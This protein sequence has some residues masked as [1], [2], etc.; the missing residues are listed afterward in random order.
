MSRRVAQAFAIG[1]RR[2]I[3]APGAVMVDGGSELGLGVSELV[4]FHDASQAFGNGRSGCLTL[5]TLRVRSARP[6]GPRTIAELSA[7]R[8]QAAA[9]ACATQADR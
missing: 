3:D 1:R 7:R 9:G 8:K 5:R 6:S 2:L 4:L